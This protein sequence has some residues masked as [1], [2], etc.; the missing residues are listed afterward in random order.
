MSA[1]MWIILAMIIFWMIVAYVMGLIMGR[2][3]GTAKSRP[4][5]ATG[6]E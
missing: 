1:E 3:I 2:A 5:Q 4:K 6:E